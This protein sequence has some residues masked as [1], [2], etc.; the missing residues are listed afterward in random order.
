MVRATLVV[1]GLAMIALAVL[2]LQ[3]GIWWEKSFNARFG[4]F[5]M[6]PTLDW[7]ALGA[8]FIVAGLLPW[9]RISNWLDKRDAGKKRSTNSFSAELS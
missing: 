8:I 6:R 3:Q 4:P 5:A 1:P 7:I 9:N 2:A